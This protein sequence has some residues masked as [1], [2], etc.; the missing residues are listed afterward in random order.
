MPFEPIYGLP[1]EAPSDIPGWSLTGGPTGNDPVLA[2]RFAAQLRRLDDLMQSLTDSFGSYPDVVQAGQVTVTPNVS[3][4]AGFYNSN[5]WR[6]STSVVFDTP[7]TSTIPAVLVCSDS[8]LPGTVI[9]C[10]ASSVTLNGFTANVARQNT[11]TTGV[12][13]VASAQTQT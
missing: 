6:G 10:S 1:Y 5:Y 8:A 13:W 11:T 3:V 7:F 9:E 4:P 2:E 12:W